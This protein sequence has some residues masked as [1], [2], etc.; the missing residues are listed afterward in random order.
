MRIEEIR[1]VQRAQPFR[2]FTLYLTD[3]RQFLVDHPE[4]MLISRSNRTVVVD[5]VAGNIEIIDLILVT[6]LTVPADGPRTSGG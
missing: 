3:G 1:K 5:D 2:P 4:F 6:G